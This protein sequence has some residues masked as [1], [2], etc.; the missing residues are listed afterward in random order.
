LRSSFSMSASSVFL[1]TQKHTIVCIRMVR[2]KP[3]C[4]HDASLYR[5]RVPW[6]KT[7]RGADVFHI[8]QT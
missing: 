7:C 3:K 1:L 8:A 5:A 6:C 2:I 4:S